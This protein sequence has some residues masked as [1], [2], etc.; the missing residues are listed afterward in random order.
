MIINVDLLLVIGSDMLLI[1]FICFFDAKQVVF[2][3]VK[4][5][6]NTHSI[7]VHKIDAIE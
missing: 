7:G 5:W 3:T 1:V 2:K 4:S 6:Y